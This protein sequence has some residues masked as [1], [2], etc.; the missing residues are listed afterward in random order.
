MANVHSQPQRE[1]IVKGLA[2]FKSPRAIAAD[3]AA[4]FPDTRCDENDVKRLDPT[5]VLLPPE[6]LELFKRERERVLLDPASAPFAEQKARI[7]V[8][9]HQ[10]QFY[11]GN[12]Q[13]PEQRAVLRQ[14]A[15]EL[16]AVSQG[17]G[18]KAPNDGKPTEPV[19]EIV[20]RI[21]DPK[22][23]PVEASA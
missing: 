4:L 20:R 13:L 16:G 3:F 10:A 12:N 9:S 7:V 1:F 2:A 14:I 6:L 5:L 11:G 21:V 18:T 17:R 15:E 19:T 8:L 22:A 23:Q